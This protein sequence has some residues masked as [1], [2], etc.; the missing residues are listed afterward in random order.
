MDRERGGDRSGEDVEL[1]VDRVTRMALYDAVRGLE[2]EV[3]A[4]STERRETAV[5]T[6]FTRVPSRRAE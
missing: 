2:L 5:S 4:F 1:H 6:D 3:E